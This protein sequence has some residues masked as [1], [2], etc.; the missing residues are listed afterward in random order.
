MAQIRQFRCPGCDYRAEVSGG[1]DR[2]LEVYTQT[3]VCNECKEIRDVPA[4]RFELPKDKQQ[5]YPDPQSKPLLSAWVK[6]KAGELQR[7]TKPDV[8]AAHYAHLSHYWKSVVLKCPNNPFHKVQPWFGMHLPLEEELEKGASYGTS[9]DTTKRASGLCPRC[10][11]HMV[12][13]Q[14]LATWE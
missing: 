6:F 7:A 9:D 12:R 14:P 3:V 2:G 1:E 8:V 11:Q 10:S 13:S 5:I 4:R